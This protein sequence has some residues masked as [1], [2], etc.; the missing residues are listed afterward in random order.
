LEYAVPRREWQ[1]CRQRELAPNTDSS[2]RACGYRGKH[3]TRS[4]CNTS[5]NDHMSPPRPR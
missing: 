4:S 3:G 5:R 2:G 1:L